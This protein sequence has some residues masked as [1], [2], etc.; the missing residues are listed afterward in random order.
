MEKNE[1][2]EKIRKLIENMSPEEFN[3]IQEMT[4]IAAKLQTNGHDFLALGIEDSNNTE[5]KRRILESCANDSDLCPTA[6]NIFKQFNKILED[7]C[8]E[9][10]IK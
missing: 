6:V 9:N 7:F 3:T 8:N 2:E 10:N 1:M 4:L 5:L